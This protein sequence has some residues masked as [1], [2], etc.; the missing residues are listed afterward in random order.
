[1]PEGLMVREQLNMLC[2]SNHKHHT[3]LQ[4]CDSDGKI[5]NIPDYTLLV[6][7]HNTLYPLAGVYESN[8]GAIQKE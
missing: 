4:F 3:L 8:E 7:A 5:S 1:M 6:M 2:M